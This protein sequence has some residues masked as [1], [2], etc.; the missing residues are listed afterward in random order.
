MH[1]M[2]KPFRIPSF[3]CMQDV[4]FLYAFISYLMI[5]PYD[6]LHPSQAPQFNNFK[7][8]LIHFPKCPSFST[9][10]SYAPKVALH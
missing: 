2:T 7:I 5:S 4:H 10:P 1:D 9:I 6:L 8:I 3:Y